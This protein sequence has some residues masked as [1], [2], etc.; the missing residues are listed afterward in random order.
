MKKNQTKTNRARRTSVVAGIVV[1]MAIG[2]CSGGSGLDDAWQ[3]P[4]NPDPPSGMPS[5]NGQG[6]L[7]GYDVGE[8]GTYTIAIDTTTTL[9]EA[10]PVADDD[11]DYVENSSFDKKIRIAYNG[12]TAAVEG[13]VDGVTVTVQ[14]ADVTVNSTAKGVD[15]ILSGFTNDGCLK[16]YSD[17]KYR[18]DLNGVTITNLDGPAINDQSGKRVFVV[19]AGGTTNTLAD[20]TGYA[21]SDEDQKGTL[22]AEGKL[23]FSGT[24]K[25]RVH[26]NTKAGISADDYVMTRP[27][28]DIYVKSTS[29]NGI[30]ANDAITI[31]GGRVNIETGGAASKGISSDGTVAINGGRT[32]IITTGGGEYDDDDKDVSGCAGVKADSTFTMNGGELLCHSKGDGGKGISTD[33]KLMVNGGTIKVIC[34]GGKY[35]YGSCD[36]SPKGIKSDGDMSIG[37]G[38]IWV[39][40]LKGEGSEGIESKAKMEISGG[41]I[42]TYTY[43]DGIN[44]KGDMTIS[45]GNITTY[46]TGNDGIDSNGNLYIKGGTVVAYGTSSPEEGIDVNS[47]EGR[48][49]YITGGT[50]VGIGGGASQPSSTGGSQPAL[51]YGGSI[52]QGSTASIKDAAGNTVLSFDMAGNYGPATFLLSASGMKSGSS[53]TLYSGNNAL[54][55]FTATTPCS[56][57]GNTSPGTGGGGQQPGGPGQGGRG[58]R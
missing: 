16:V 53:Y 25:L 58:P 20:G 14:N 9:T 1:A 49:L 52:S 56:T 32:T 36:T 55:T 24:G 39:R 35:T 23:L 15:Y 44:S 11:E 19:L 57:C 41:D 45:G 28:T 37:G 38:T 8:I 30:K 3:D 47:E 54:T 22:F 33:Q 2:S 31:N 13:S 48:K 18:L 46:A 6:G 43:D 34:D 7:S 17:K 50:V 5:G 10:D 4:M 27:G 21:K 40:T 42:T 12:S 29:G 26:A 51:I